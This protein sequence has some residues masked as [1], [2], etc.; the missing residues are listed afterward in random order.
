MSNLDIAELPHDIKNPADGSRVGHIYK[1]GNYVR[2]QVGIDGLT[3][4]FNGKQ[5]MK[6][7]LPCQV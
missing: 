3:A 4:G 1:K 7:N 5:N 6:I 2:V